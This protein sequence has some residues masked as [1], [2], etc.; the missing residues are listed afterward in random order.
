[1]AAQTK[2]SETWKNMTA[3]Y[4]K[5]GE[6]WKIAKSAWIKLDDNK[7]RNW[8]L[9]GG[10]N[11][12][13]FNE[14]D[15]YGT[16][17]AS[18][19]TVVVQSDEKIVM[20]GSFTAFN[21]TVVNRIIRLNND[22]TL[23][24][25]FS[26]N[27]G[28]G[29]NNTVRGIAIQPDGKIVVAGDFTAFNG[30]A[31]PR[32]V[33]LNTDGTLDTA[34]TINNG[35]GPNTNVSSVAT[36]ADGKIVVVGSF[37]F[38]NQVGGVNR[39]VRLNSDGTRDTAFNTNTGTG[40]SAEGRAVAIQSDGK[41][42]VGGQFTTFN[43]TTVNRIVRLNA[44]GTLDA[45]FNIN[46]GTGF[47][48][49]TTSLAIQ[50]DGKIVVGGQ[51]TTFNGTTVNRIVRLNAD[52]TL[53]TAFSTNT[54]TGT[55]SNVDSLAIQPDGKIVIGGS[56]ASFN[57]TT[58]NRIA[59]LNSDGTLDTA[60]TINNG[61]GANSSVDSLAIQTDGKI[62][63]V[64]NFTTFNEVGVNFIVRLG[65]SGSFG[66][67]PI[68]EFFGANNTV[69]RIAIQPDGKIV[70][71]GDFTRFNGTTVNRI[72][73]L[74]SDGTLDTQFSAN[75]G[76]GANGNITSLAIQSNGKIII[77]GSL[78]TFNG[79]S[80]NCIMCLNSDGTRDTAFTNNTG[81][82]YFGTI[83]SLAIQP[84]DKIVAVGSLGS[85]NFQSANR[86][87][88]LNSDGTRDSSF[89]TNGGS[90]L[91]NNAHSVAI[92][93]DGKIV[94]G[95][96]FTAFNG[97][98]TP[99]I[100][101]LNTDGTLDT[102]FSANG[103]SGANSQVN[104]VAIQP[105]GKIVIGG[106]FASFNGTTANGI[107]RLNSDGTLDT[108]FTINNGTGANGTVDSLAIQTDGK[109]V[110][111]GQFT[112][113]NGTTVNRIARL[114]SNGTRDTAFTDNTGTGATTATSPSFLIN[115]IAIQSD[116][117]I[118]LGGQFTVFSQKIRTRLARISGDIA[119]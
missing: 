94:I 14:E 111:G 106:F 26:N 83:N 34:F 2:V 51:F 11:D 110:V 85:F 78:T 8:F 82:A 58:A 31:T 100:V 43:G 62:V 1:M 116:G 38:F 18:V 39:I 59:R 46:T 92:Q 21:G 6:S 13:G 74:N 80:V 91:S 61:T 68:K 54:G 77:G 15:S 113:F 7:W 103:G 20:G 4:I 9:Q 48:S 3:P 56:F 22:G 44:D 101:R 65:S 37:T 88:R 49:T 23:D 105:D 95:G 109:I 93:P 97:V 72:A 50:S 30:V 28:F 117:K 52:G 112:T 90:G 66:D 33:R 102:Q 79:A 70:V 73:R 118:I 98:A 47:N 36:Q 87:I 41:I 35:T 40:A 64:G 24:T 16:F 10:L 114:N 5:I 96:F 81:T 71:A 60:F 45:V 107:A 67:I 108:A 27:T 53:D 104:S 55:N 25:E 63:V 69:R 29:A 19:R 17:D 76:T 119:Q 115:S 99:R 57:G 12:A 86:L 75:T 84:D 32:I 89:S 42:V